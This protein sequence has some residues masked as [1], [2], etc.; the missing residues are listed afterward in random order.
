MPLM[1]VRYSVFKEGNFF[2]K[3]SE[4]LICLFWKQFL[5]AGKK[6]RSRRRRR[7]KGLSLSKTKEWV[8]TDGKKLNA[9]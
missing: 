8:C 5:Q 6:E 2:S 1:K 4:F 3:Q 7:D 9:E